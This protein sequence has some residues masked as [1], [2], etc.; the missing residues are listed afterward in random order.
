MCQWQTLPQWKGGVREAVKRFEA[1][2]EG[3]GRQK[4]KLP[5]DC[6]GLI[7]AATNIQ[8]DTESFLDQILTRSSQRPKRGNCLWTRP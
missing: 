8:I 2:L 4:S 3:D 1:W 6:G 5:V 7:H